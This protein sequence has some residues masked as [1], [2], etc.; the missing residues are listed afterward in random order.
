MY[1]IK[2][3]NI[4]K[5]RHQASNSDYLDVSFDILEV[6]NE[7]GPNGEANSQGKVVASR[8]LGF[9]PTITQEELRAELRKV[10][11]AYQLEQE[12]AA[13]QAELDK[14][15]ENVTD[16]KEGLEGAEFDVSGAEVEPEGEQPQ[17]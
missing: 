16:L 11:N 14:V 2:V 3:K 6:S 5:A 17:E 15:D 12:Q 4:E 13:K 1:K 8:R 10:A 7:P 9:E